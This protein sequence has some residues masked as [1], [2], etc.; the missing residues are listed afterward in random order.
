MRASASLTR[1]KT[2]LPPPGRGRDRL[3]IGVCGETGAGSG[4]LLPL[5]GRLEAAEDRIAA[6]DHAVDAFLHRDLVGEDLLPAVADLVADLQEAAKPRAMGGGEL[7]RSG[8]A[9]DGDLAALV[10]R[11]IVEAVG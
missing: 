3:G 8:Q 1:A 4:Q 7:I 10:F 2:E 5:V 6:L 11:I 9:G